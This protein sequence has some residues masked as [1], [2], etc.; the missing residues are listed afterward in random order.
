MSTPSNQHC[1]L[2]GHGTFHSC[3]LVPIGHLPLLVSFPIVS[4]AKLAIQRPAPWSDM[5]DT[6]R[7]P[8]PEVLKLSNSRWSRGPFRQVLQRAESVLEPIKR[9]FMM[10]MIIQ[11]LRRIISEERY[12]VN[13]WCT[14][15]K[16]TW[17]WIVESKRLSS[18][19]PQEEDRICLRDS[20]KGSISRWA[21]KLC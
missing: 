17:F 2:V 14:G 11:I 16:L 7:K 15:S 21:S 13:F 19:F 3:L 1:Y 4:W 20:N 10:I 12:S 9:L 8:L 5:F 18:R 6:S